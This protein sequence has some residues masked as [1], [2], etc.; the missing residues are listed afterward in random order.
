MQRTNR[1]APMVAALRQQFGEVTVDGKRLETLWIDPP[2]ASAETIVMLHEGLGSIA[3]WKDFP[4]Q[5]AAR[6]GCRNT[7]KG[8]SRLSARNVLNP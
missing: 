2:G 4:Q 5:L 6:T 3:L 7:L 8:L 1:P